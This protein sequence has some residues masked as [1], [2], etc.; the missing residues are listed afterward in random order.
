MAKLTEDR[1]SRREKQVWEEKYSKYV[2]SY[3][4]IFLAVP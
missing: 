3:Y 2:N 4:L 1:A